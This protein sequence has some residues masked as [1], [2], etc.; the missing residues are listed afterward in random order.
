MKGFVH[1]NPIYDCK[2]SHLWNL[3]SGPPDQLA[4]AES[5]FRYGEGLTGPRKTKDGRKLLAYLT[6][7]LLFIT[8]LLREGLLPYFSEEEPR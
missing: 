6:Y 8:C 3:N 7:S 1:L 5:T 4:S 2:D